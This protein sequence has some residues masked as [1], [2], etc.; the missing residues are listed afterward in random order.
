M[1]RIC[2]LSQMNFLNKSTV[3][4]ITNR[5]KTKE[6]PGPFSGLYIQPALQMQLKRAEN[7]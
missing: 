5:R 1:V 4:K 2:R 6:K 3:L 7:L